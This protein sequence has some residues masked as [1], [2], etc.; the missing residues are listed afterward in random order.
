MNWQQK[1]HS[2]EKN[3]VAVIHEPGRRDLLRPSSG[4]ALHQHPMT[5][6]AVWVL[7]IDIPF[8]TVICVQM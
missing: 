8:V 4:F 6:G 5:F 7:N 2:I 1:V 3:V